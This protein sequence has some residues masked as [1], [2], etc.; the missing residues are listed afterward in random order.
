MKS[1]DDKKAKDICSFCQCKASTTLAFN[2]TL[3][4]FCD[5]CKNK[6]MSISSSDSNYKD[7]NQM[8]KMRKNTR[9]DIDEKY[10][11]QYG[12]IVDFN[13]TPQDIYNQLSKYIVGQDSAKKKLSVAIRRHYRRVSLRIKEQWDDEWSSEEITANSIPKENV[14]LIGPTGCGKTYT[15]RT[16]SNI[17]SVPFWMAAMTAFTEDGYVGES[18]ENLISSLLREAGYYNP[19]A[20]CGILFLDEIDKKA[21]KTAGNPSISRDVSGE[22]VQSAILDMI[23]TQGSIMNVGLTLGNRRN[24]QRYTEKFNTRDVLFILGG[25][26]PGLVDIIQKRVHGKKKI[27]FDVEHYTFADKQKFDNEILHNVLPEDIVAYGFI[28]E[29][30][31]RLGIISVLDPLSKDDMKSILLDTDNAIIKQQNILASIENINIDF[32]EEAINTIIDQAIESGMGARRLKAI[33]S[34][35]TE[36]IFFDLSGSNKMKKVRVLPETVNNPSKYEIICKNKNA[37]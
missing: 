36:Q 10:I 11:L 24:S 4:N 31:G 5:N 15:C 13:L 7:L 34:N 12:K 9:D 17:V 22:G 23:D 6:Y 37:G 32:T 35:T 19:L 3:V 28:P 26:F 25:A 14:L 1:M 29:L 30:V 21:M 33:V 2:N 18:V 8:A 20:E 27:G 16:L